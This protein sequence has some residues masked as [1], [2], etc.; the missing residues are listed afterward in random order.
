M[1]FSDGGEI[2]LEGRL[3]LRASGTYNQHAEFINGQRESRRFL[4]EL[5]RLRVGLEQRQAALRA[6]VIAARRSKLR[7]L[8]QQPALGMNLPGRQGDGAVNG[9][10]LRAAA[11][12]R[13]GIGQPPPPQVRHQESRLL[14]V[15]GGQ[16]AGGS[17]IAKSEDFAPRVLDHEPAKDGLPQQVLGLFHFKVDRIIHLGKRRGGVQPYGKDE[18]TELQYAPQPLQLNGPI[19]DSRQRPEDPYFLSQNASH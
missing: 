19:F 1:G 16:T 5:S 7:P 6:H 10:P 11:G 17:A 4:R 8:V 3:N 14:V 9:S 12:P 2:G 13:A 15:I 18:Q